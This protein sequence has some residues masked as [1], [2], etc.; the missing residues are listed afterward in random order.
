MNDV[1]QVS[2]RDSLG[3]EVAFAPWAFLIIFMEFIMLN[4]SYH[5]WLLHQYYYGFNFENLKI[6]LKTF[7][8]QE[9]SHEDPPCSSKLKRS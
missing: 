8:L 4:H 5:H 2:R 9:I 7:N 3:Q 6:I 1:A